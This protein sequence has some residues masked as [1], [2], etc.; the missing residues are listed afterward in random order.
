MVYGMILL[1]H[2]KWDQ[3]EQ[4]F[5]IRAFAK[6]IGLKVDSFFSY[7]ENVDFSDVRNNDTVI[8]YDW[9]CI[10]NSRKDISKFIGQFV[11]NHIYVY[12]AQSK[13]RIDKHCN[14]EQLNA[15]FSLF[16]DIRFRFLSVQNTK[17][18]QSRVRSGRYRGGTNQKHVWDGL[19]QNILSMY[20]AGN[21]MYAIGK[22]LKLIPSSVRRFLIS[23]NKRTN[24][25]DK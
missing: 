20:E 18:V 8:F 17:V 4:R 7:T 9:S 15:A 12:S 11:K 19:E 10:C 16:E 5:G 25:A 14:F 3:N 24:Y 21:T 23:K 13:Y 2:I 1:G 6:K 22:K